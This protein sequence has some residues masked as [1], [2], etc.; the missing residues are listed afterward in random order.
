MLATRRQQ[1]HSCLSLEGQKT[2]QPPAP[3]R[4]SGARALQ[5]H[6]QILQGHRPLPDDTTWG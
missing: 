4:V 2:L 6:R 3:L 1:F 5:H